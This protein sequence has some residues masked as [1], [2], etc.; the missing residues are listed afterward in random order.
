[1]SILNSASFLLCYFRRVYLMEHLRLG[2][3][4]MVL[5]CVVKCKWLDKFFALTNHYE[6]NKK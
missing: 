3:T 4:F 1:M 6:V 2:K 5:H